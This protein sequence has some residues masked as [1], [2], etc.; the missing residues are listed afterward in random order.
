MAS[1]SRY[2]SDSSDAEWA[3][4]A[5]YLTLMREAAPQ[6]QY[7]LR[8]VF[9]ALRW[10]VRT[11][12][13]WRYLPHDFPP[14]WVVYQQSQRW[15]AAGCFEAITQ[16]LRRLLREAQ[17]RPPEPTATILDARTLRSTPESGHRAGFDGYKRKN[18]SKVHLAVDTL[19]HLLALTV[20]PAN[21]AE[22]TQ[23]GALTEAVQQ[24]TEETVQIAFADQGYTGD[25]AKEQ[26]QA[27]GVQLHVVRPEQPQKGFV[28]MPRRWVVE[29]SFAWIARFRRLNRDYERLQR[30]LVQMHFAA[31]TALMLAKLI[32]TLPSA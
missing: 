20:T 11:G 12:S 27:H 25:A 26:A 23:V 2:P 15:F 4:A 30:T 21:H 22:Q 32:H 1:R 13:P 7:A 24:A 9:D 17:G 28:L 6:R 18:G 31:F 16:A 29:R 3:F 10:L 5:P 14:W 19:G 8:D